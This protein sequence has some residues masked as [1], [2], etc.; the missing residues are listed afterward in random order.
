MRV[1]YITNFHIQLLGER[2][3]L[4][5]R[6]TMHPVCQEGFRGTMRRGSEEKGEIPLGR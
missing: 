1:S 4:M 3:V 5:Y 6:T 2:G